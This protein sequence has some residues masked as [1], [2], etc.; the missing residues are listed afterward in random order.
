MITPEYAITLIKNAGG[1]PILAH[2]LLYKL[3]YSEIETMLV[4]FLLIMDLLESKPIILQ[5]I[6]MKPINSEVLPLNII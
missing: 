5:V 2:P 4:T 3:S 1:K 6:G